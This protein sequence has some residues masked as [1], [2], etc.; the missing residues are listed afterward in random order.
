MEIMPLRR[1]ARKGGDMSARK[2]ASAG[3]AELLTS[4]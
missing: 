1:F 3:D 2:S 4:D